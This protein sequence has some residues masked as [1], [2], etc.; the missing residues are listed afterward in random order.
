VSIYQ[1]IESIA[2]IGSTKA[3]QQI[4]EDNKTNEVLKNT[5]LYTENPRFN[6]Y[7]KVEVSNISDGVND[8]SMSTFTQL[9]KLINREYTGNAARRFVDGMMSQLTQEAQIILARII[10]KDLRCNC[11][12]SISNKVWKDL[13][14]EYPMMLAQPGKV[15]NLDYIRKKEGKDKL[16]AQKKSDGGRVNIIVTEGD[17]VYRSRSGS[18]LDL[19]GF[20]DAQFSNLQNVVIDGEL[21]VRTET[22]I[23]DR[24]VGNGLYT[25]AVRGTLSKEEVTKM[26][27]E[28]WDIIP[29]AEFESGKGTEPYSKRLANLILASEKFNPGLISVIETKVVDT[30]K[31]C[32]EFYAEMR[33]RGE[34]G[35]IIKVA[36]GVWE[37]RRSKD[38]VKMKA[39]ET[40]DLLCVGW[41]EGTG[42]NRG[43]IGNLILETSDGLL[44]T[45]CGTGLTDAD[46]ARDPSYYV[47]KI[48]ETCY[49]EVIESKDPK[50]KT[51][52]LFLPVY[53][54]VRFDKTM[55]NKLSELK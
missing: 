41:E 27:I 28:V 13:I 35:A 38:M 34:E 29:L 52:S 54:Q 42:K 1:I 3:K 20:F 45:G 25:K 11:G 21:L 10:N 4:L 16:I 51:K 8:I 44:R 43:L 18:E 47:G 49:N 14:P 39:E 40:A 6:F 26:C 5:F 46:R 32:V 30:L 17:V 12:T 31:Q 22:G 15:K 53:K 33:S 36:D 37:D 24:K 48:I 55:A 50:V 23:A 9:D 7:I 19:H 2:A